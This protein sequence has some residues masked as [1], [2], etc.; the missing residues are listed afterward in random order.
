MPLYSIDVRIYG[1]AYIRADNAAE[2]QAAA[3]GLKG[4]CFEFPQGYIGDDVEISGRQYD[5][6]DLPDLS[7]SPAMTCHGP[8]EGATVDVADDGGEDEDEDTAPAFLALPAALIEAASE[9]GPGEPEPVDVGRVPRLLADAEAFER[10]GDTE[11]AKECRAAAAL[12]C[13]VCG[14]DVPASAEGICDSC[15]PGAIA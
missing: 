7:L 8:D 9:E 2:A 5:D 15:L 3:D 10:T 13:G 14:V 11:Q 4:C 6:P 1:T 12:I